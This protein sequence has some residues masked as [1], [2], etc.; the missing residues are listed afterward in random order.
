LAIEV[1]T[2]ALEAAPVEFLTIV[3]SN[4]M[5][6]GITAAVAGR[7]SG[8]IFN[9]LQSMVQLQ[10]ISDTIA[11]SYAERHGS[12]HWT[13]LEG[14]FQQRLSCPKLE[15]YWTFSEC[16]YRKSAGTCSQPEHLVAC[17]LPDHPLRKGG[18]N[19]S[20]YS[21]F[22]FIRDVC[23][24]D[25]IEWIDQ[26][27]EQA[28]PGDAASDRAPRMRQALLTPLCNVYGVS[29]KLWS[30]ALSELL[31]GGPPERERWVTT[32]AWMVAVDTLVHNFLHR[33]GVLR[34]LGAE[35]A[36]GPRCYAPA[37]CAEIIEG[38]ATRINARDFNSDFPAVFPRFV[39]H[40]I[41]RFCAQDEL[42]ICNGNQ[43]DDRRPCE[44]ALCP[45][46]ASCERVALRHP[47]GPVASGR[48]HSPKSEL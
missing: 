6:A 10:G 30:M 31:L 26:R 13:L 37:G 28:D 42:N 20:A 22:L 15:C 12:V 27:L 16:G 1:I 21:L 23:D 47:G 41:W 38:L 43:I 45:A 44:N 29:A 25:L 36:Y 5:S 40:A 2:P 39:Q 35:H 32:G 11:S 34:R 19:Q 48:L 33:T 17:P 18:L 14:S 46:Y 8:A 9:W 7:D 4:M 3:R 24:N